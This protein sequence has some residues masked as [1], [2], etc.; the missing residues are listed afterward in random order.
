MTALLSINELS[1]SYKQ[2]K[3]LQG[4]SCDLDLGIH[5]LLGPNGSGKSTLMNLLTQNLKKDE[6]EILFKGESIDSL[7]SAYRARLGFMPQTAGVPAGFTLYEFLLYMACLKGISRKE[8]K[9]QAEKLMEA[10]ELSDCKNR[11]VSTFS[12]GMK[13]RALLAQAL[14]GEPDLLILDEP[15]AGLDP[16]QRLK[17]KNLLS[18][19]GRKHCV[20]IATHIVSDVEGLSSH[21]LFLKKGLLVAHGAP[22]DLK[23]S[24]TGLFWDLP[25][26]E[27]LPSHSLVKHL[28]TGAR[29]FS[30]VKPSPGAVPATP[31]LE[32]CYYYHFGEVSL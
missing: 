25:A 18:S 24:L 16:M 9:S 22:R 6:G 5:A 32:D 2:V 4:F 21:L 13:Q 10:V 1:K 8:A 12:G 31:D 30:T 19:Y 14:L 28:P 17:V 23:A 15:T 3:A 20:L 29:V 7:G 11:K 26:T 27:L